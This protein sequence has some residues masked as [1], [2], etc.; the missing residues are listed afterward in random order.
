MAAA[1]GDRVHL[2]SPV[3][4]VLAGAGFTGAIVSTQG[5]GGTC[6][7]VTP[8]SGTP[9]GLLAFVGGDNARQYAGQPALRKAVLDELVAWP[10]ALTADR[11]ALT[12]PVGRVHWAGTETA[13]YWHGYMDGAIS[14]RQRVAVEVQRALSVTT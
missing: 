7:D 10:G 6:Y 4:A 11:D 1:L 12:R 8:A 13:T 5:P 3:P 2:S 9:G 14:S